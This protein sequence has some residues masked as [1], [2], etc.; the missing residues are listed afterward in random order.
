MYENFRKIQCSDCIILMT[1]QVTCIEIIQSDEE[2]LA[3]HF[4]NDLIS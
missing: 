2:I 1:E 4:C 3:R